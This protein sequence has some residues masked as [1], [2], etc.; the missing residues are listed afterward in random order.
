[1]KRPAKI[2]LWIVGSVFGVFVGIPIIV[3]IIMAVIPSN[4]IRHKPIPP[5][6]G[7]KATGP[8]A[9]ARPAEHPQAVARRAESPQRVAK[10]ASYAID[11]EAGDPPGTHTKLEQAANLAARG[12][13]CAEVIEV[14]YVPPADRFPGHKN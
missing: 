6:H 8:K 7:A 3:G 13:N 11:D 9:N 14:A 1:M 2:A 12:P 4:P 5:P 10:I